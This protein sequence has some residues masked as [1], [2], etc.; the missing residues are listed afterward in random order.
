MHFK[1]QENIEGLKGLLLECLRYVFDW[2]KGEPFIL[3]QFVCKWRS[4]NYIPS[5]SNMLFY[6]CLKGFKGFFI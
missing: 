4:Q 3:D 6:S 5:P 1:L 2:H